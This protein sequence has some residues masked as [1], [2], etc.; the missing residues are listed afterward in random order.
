MPITATFTLITVSEPGGDWAEHRPADPRQGYASGV[1][2]RAPSGLFPGGR[3]RPTF[4]EPHPVRGGAVAL[5]IASATTWL[6]LVGS[7][8]GTVRGYAWLTIAASAVAGVLALVL[9]RFGD[10]GVAA[11]VAAGTAV[12]L[13][14]AMAVVV[15]RWIVSGWPLW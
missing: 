8:G 1:D 13:S 2:P 6:L 11:G 15:Q 14:I 5:G 9:A 10:R 4:R 7:L 12:G 3:T